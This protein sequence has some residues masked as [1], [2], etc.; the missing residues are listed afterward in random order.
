MLKGELL[1]PITLSPDLKVNQEFFKS[2]QRKILL[3]VAKD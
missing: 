1:I 2:M 3:S